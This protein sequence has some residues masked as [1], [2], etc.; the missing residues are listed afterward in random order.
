MSKG[1]IL[2]NKDYSISYCKMKNLPMD[3]NPKK[4]AWVMLPILGNEE[5]MQKFLVLKAKNLITHFKSC[6][7]RI[8]LSY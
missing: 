1:L 4:T 5:G 6:V 2:L 8:S 7:I 3:L